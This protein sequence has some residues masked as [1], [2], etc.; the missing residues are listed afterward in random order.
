MADGV[1]LFGK[2]WDWGKEMGDFKPEANED[3]EFKPLTG[4]Y[5]ARIADCFHDI[6]AFPSGDMYDRYTLSLQVTET[7]DG[8][9]G[10]NRYL[11]KRYQNTPEGVHKLANDLFTAG[12]TVDTSSKEAFDLSLTDTKDKLMNV[13]AWVWTPDKTREGA[14]IPEEE[15]EG[16]Q[17]FAIIKEF[18]QKK[19]QTTTGEVPF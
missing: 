12:I 8:D 14:I 19:Q 6:G 13:R 1:A 2:D 11:R 18:K 7:I 5:I 17:Q 16:R 4:R 10:T 3:S 9:R 15:R